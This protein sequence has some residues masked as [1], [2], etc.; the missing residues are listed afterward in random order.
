MTE[1]NRSASGDSSGSGS[2]SHGR[3]SGGSSSNGSNSRSSGGSSGSGSNGESSGGSGGNESNDR[4]SGGGSGSGS[5]GG[6]SGGSSDD[7]SSG[8][9]AADVAERLR[10]L[11]VKRSLVLQ[12]LVTEFLDGD[13]MTCELKVIMVQTDTGKTK[14]GKTYKKFTETP[15]QVFGKNSMFPVRSGKGGGFLP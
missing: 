5:N 9:R 6:S 1:K 7:S 4:S 11:R 12:D 8:S 14:E 2:G 15:C 10:T 3:S 13:I